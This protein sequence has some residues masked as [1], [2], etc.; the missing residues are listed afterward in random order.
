MKPTQP[1]RP[2]KR[3]FTRIKR[4][5]FVQCR[6]HETTGSWSSVTLQDISQGGMSFFSGKEFAIGE[7][8]DINIITFIRREPIYVKGK[9]VG[10]QKDNEGKNRISRISIVK[11]NEEDSAV[12][13]ELIRIFLDSIKSKEE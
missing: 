10:A 5:L 1:G 9:V 8:L 6:P 13:Q 12:F 11:I 3:Q 7:V 2:E 4:T